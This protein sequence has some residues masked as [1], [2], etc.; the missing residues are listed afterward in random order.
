MLENMIALN[1]W[2]YSMTNMKEFLI[3]QD[4]LLR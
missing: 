3:E 4:I 1:I 2:D